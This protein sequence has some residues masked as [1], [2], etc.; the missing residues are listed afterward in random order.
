MFL[1]ITF[2]V[3]SAIFFLIISFFL[4]DLWS[5]YVPVTLLLLSLYLK[6]IQPGWS[7]NTVKMKTIKMEPSAA[8][9]WVVIISVIY[10]LISII[11][12]NWIEFILCVVIFLLSLTMKFERPRGPNEIEP[13]F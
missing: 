6:I 1:T 13:P 11:F 2:F 9:G 10:G 5:Y 3:I 12:G 8:A 4:K 7:T